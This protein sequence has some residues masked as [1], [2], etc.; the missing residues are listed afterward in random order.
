MIITKL[1]LSGAAATGKS[2]LIALLLGQPPVHKHDS[3]LL[4]R[5]LRHARLTAGKDDLSQKWESYDD[6][7]ELLEL[8]ADG[9]DDV[10]TVDQLEQQS[11]STQE[12]VHF[13]SEETST[14]K[15][16]L[17][18]SRTLDE[19]VLKCEVAAKS[20]RLQNIHWIYTVDSGGQPA[21]LDIL[22]AFIRCHSVTMHTVKLNKALNDPVEMVFSVRGETF[23]AP[24]KLCL[25]NLQLIKTLVRSV[26]STYFKFHPSSQTAVPRCIIV[27]TFKDELE[28]ELEDKLKD[29]FKTEDYERAISRIDCQLRNSLKYSSKVLIECQDGLIFPVNTVVEGK[30]R[31]KV[32]V[33]LRKII[34]DTNGTSQEIDIPVRWFVF[35]LEL[36]KQAEAQD[37]GILSIDKCKEVGRRFEMNDDEVLECVKYLHEQTLLL[38]FDKCLPN[39]VFI[40]AQSILDK[41]SAIL[42]LTYIDRSKMCEI[43]R[44]LPF[45][46]SCDDLKQNGLF[47]RDLIDNLHILSPKF[48]G[49]LKV[50][51]PASFTA[52][53]FFELLEYLLVIAQVPVQDEYMYFIPC[54]LPTQSPSK[55][56]KTDY[57]K[58][59]SELVLYWKDMPIPQGLFPALVV[60][61]LQRETNPCFKIPSQSYQE[62]QL[63]HAIIL[64]SDSTGGGI[65]LVDSVDWLE[66]Y[67]TGQRSNCPQ[68]YHAILEGISEIVTKFEYQSKIRFPIEGF[69]CWADGCESSPHPCYIRKKESIST[70]YCTMA[71]WKNCMCSDKHLCWFEKADTYGTGT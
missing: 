33:E 51:F 12:P 71:H 62:Q 15:T 10:P 6:P 53:N 54:V 23:A 42:L 46:A 31:E 65:L 22:P 63:R 50:T 70:A 41:V 27:G 60:Q 37:Q 30:E 68:I 18:T 25:T 66:V 61:L 39:T 32:A 35:E 57:S 64:S 1:L 38:Y 21:F 9:I 59:N 13:L 69:I 7:E 48:F 2:S 56:Q 4:S 36:R 24:E 40:H 52:E 29:Q 11:Q 44:L 28:N 55:Q 26:S 67:F 19:L 47:N 14:Q 16:L 3:T 8:L 43:K 17:P 45:S 20:N 5:P 58:Q 34:A 49:E